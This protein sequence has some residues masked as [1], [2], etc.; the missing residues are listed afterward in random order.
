MI[1]V[2]MVAGMSSRFG[3]KIKQLAKIG[4]NNETLIEVSVN[5]A[6][7]NKK[8]SK[9]FFITNPKTDH[10]FIELFGYSY[11][12]IPIFY[13]QQEFNTII[14][15]RPWGTTGAVCSLIGHIEEPF[16][17]LNG[18]DLYGEETFNIGYKLLEDTKNNIIGGCQLIDTL[19]E[20]GTVNRGVID[21]DN[22][23]NNVVGMKEMLKI[24][25]K[26]NPE[27]HDKLANVNFI[28]LQPE[29]LD[30]LNKILLSFKL[31]HKNDDSIECLLTDNLNSLIKENKINM[32]SFIIN[33]KIHGIT[34]PGDDIKLKEY[35]EKI[36]S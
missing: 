13:V 36:E 10:K 31:E 1:T 4:P 34:N 3:G 11:K 30:L 9:I 2:F 20:E 17:L 5:Q 27:L 14:R 33:N 6:I 23:N 28:G 15:K 21:V 22:N 29:I 16:I 18:D 24:S 25:K 19:P 12:D 8:L 32:T 35:L 26:D 7:K